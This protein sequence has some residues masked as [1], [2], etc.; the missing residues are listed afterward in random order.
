MPPALGAGADARAQPGGG[1]RRGTAIRVSGNEAQAHTD[2]RLSTILEG[3]EPSTTD[4]E[5]AVSDDEFLD[6]RSLL[7]LFSDFDDD[8]TYAALS[9]ALSDTSSVYVEADKQSELDELGCYLPE[10][11]GES[12]LSSLPVLEQGVM[13]ARTSFL[14][15]TSQD[16]NEKVYLEFPG[17][18]AKLIDGV[19][20]DL[21]IG[22]TYAIAQDSV[23]RRKQIVSTDSDLLTPA[24]IKEHRKDVLEAQRL[25]L[26][27]WHKH[28]CFA[29]RPR[30]H[31]RNVIDCRWVL[32]WKVVVEANGTRRTIRA[33]LTVR[34]FKDRDAASLESY[35]G[36]S[37]RWSQRVVASQ[38]VLRQ[39]RIVSA[40]VA[41]A[42]LQGVHTR[43]WPVLLA[44]HY[45]KSVLSSRQVAY[46]C[47][48]LYLA[49]PTST[50]QKRYWPVQSQALVSE[51]L[52]RP[53]A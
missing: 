33:R 25:E 10:M 8:S 3:T 19:T 40:D 50:P 21:P 24:E 1:V 27:T 13:Q 51:T 41:K 42:F 44:N 48:A 47:C 35:A 36:T 12:L 16:S 20:E 49:T 22:Q 38:A 7:T 15:D 52:P 4:A 29:R 53:L 43:N 6:A 28:G 17:E 46:T 5:T 45:G 11:S 18:M 39:W 37:T 32:K 31:A 23:T 30:K 34:G 9:S 14:P 2:K 26:A